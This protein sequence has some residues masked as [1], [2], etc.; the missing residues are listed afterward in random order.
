MVLN[1]EC[2]YSPGDISQ[3]LAT[4][5][6]VINLEELGDTGIC[7]VEASRAA[8]QQTLSWFKMSVGSR[9]RN[10]ALDHR[11]PADPGWAQG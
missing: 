8:P 6:V 4:F 3:C 11:R 1:Q 7:W 5:L 10:L 9:L 2:L